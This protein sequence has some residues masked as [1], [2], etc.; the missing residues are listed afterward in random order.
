MRDVNPFLGWEQQDAPFFGV[1]DLFVYFI[2]R[3]QNTAIFPITTTGDHLRKRTTATPESDRGQ[4]GGAIRF[5][6]SHQPPGPLPRVSPLSGA[7]HGQPARAPSNHQLQRRHPGSTVPSTPHVQRFAFKAG[8]S[9]DSADLPG[10]QLPA[11]LSST[12]LNYFVQRRQFLRFGGFPGNAA[13]SSAQLCSAPLC[14]ITSSNEKRLPVPPFCGVGFVVTFPIK[15]RKGFLDSFILK[16]LAPGQADDSPGQAP[17][18]IP[19]EVSTP[20]VLDLPATGVHCVPGCQATK[21]WKTS[22]KTPCH[23]QSR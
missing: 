9:Y 13:P 8:N 18:S 15:K 6:F 3:G 4:V 14:S 7:G 16:N 23:W 5:A 17:S 21:K 10:T 2:V 22:R 19:A 11:Q 1:P 20:T 12:L